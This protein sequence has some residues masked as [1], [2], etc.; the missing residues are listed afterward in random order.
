M[1]TR[2]Q[3]ALVFYPVLLALVVWPGGER[4]FPGWPF[5]L[6]SAALALQAL[7]EFYEGCRAAGYSPREPLGYA[8][9]LFFL[10]LATPQFR[11][12]GPRALPLG[13]TVLSIAGLISEVVRADR[14]PLK[15]LPVTWLGALYV[16]WLLPYALRL[17]LFDPA[18][19][20]RLGWMLPADWR[21]AVGFG[22]WLLIFTL[23]VTA[24]VDTGAYAV[25]KSMGKHK[26]APVLSPGKTWEGAAG[27]FLLAILTA[28]G[29]AALLGLPLRFALTAGALI[30]VFA[31]LGDLAKSA[32]KRE[33]GIKDFG[34]LI[35]GH[36]GVLDRFD[37]LLF[38]APLVY[39]LAQAWLRFAP[40]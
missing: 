38:T 27:G 25:G 2:V 11:V 14:A 21:A 7:R 18:D 36:G 13:L 32:M 39:W 35:P 24:M 22:P 15:S 1:R 4:P 33:I 23:L 12:D 34:T 3:S 37:S 30:G 19:A 29:I 16:G 40:G 6:L 20:A 17:R 26:M 10:M 5:A 8:A 31:Q 9:A 28:W